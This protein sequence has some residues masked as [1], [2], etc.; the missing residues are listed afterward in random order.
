MPFS[1]VLFVLFIL[2]NYPWTRITLQFDLL[3]CWIRTGLNECES[4]IERKRKRE[5]ERCYNLTR[6][7]ILEISELNTLEECLV[8]PSSKK[9]G[10]TKREKSSMKCT[11][12][13]LCIYPLSFSSFFFSSSFSSSSEI[14]SLEP[15]NVVSCISHITFVLFIYPY[16][17]YSL[18]VDECAV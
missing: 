1:F 14:V 16:C 15:A 11:I 13:S 5:R 9:I 6:H 4:H 8:W 17:C 3:Y 7:L 12:L 2:L 18:S 10:K